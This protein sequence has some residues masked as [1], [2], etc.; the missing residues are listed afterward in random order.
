[1]KD[2]DVRGKASKQEKEEKGS[3][4]KLRHRPGHRLAEWVSLTISALILL[5]LAGY[6]VYEAFQANE[7][8]VPVE[9][10]PRTAEVRQVDDGRFILP[11][12]IANRGQQ[13]L[14]DLNIE[15]SYQPPDRQPETTEIL[16]DYVGERSEHTVYFYLDQDPAT[17]KPKV[18]A[19]SYRLD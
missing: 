2:A 14:R 7:P 5:T 17:L 3:G 6:L 9:V 12:F 1:M 18:R 4:R 11:V 13:T 10:Q 16:I 19:T 15:L 8:Y